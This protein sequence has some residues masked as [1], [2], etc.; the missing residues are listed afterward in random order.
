MP[1]PPFGCADA[2]P[3]PLE[4]VVAGLAAASRHDLVLAIIP[5]A[6]AVAA[7]AATALELTAIQALVPVALV[8]MA[9]IVYACYVN[10][11]IEPGSA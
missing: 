3:E 10:P 1:G 9:A 11:P 7:V 2:D 5:L 8:G 4:A 6:F